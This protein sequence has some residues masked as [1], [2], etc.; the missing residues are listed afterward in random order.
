MLKKMLSITMAGL[1]GLFGLS[2]CAGKEN[3]GSTAEAVCLSG[4]SFFLTK[5]CDLIK[6]GELLSIDFPEGSEAAEAGA[7]YKV[8]LEEALRESWPPQG[9]ARK[10]EKVKEKS[11]VIKINWDQAE[12]IM[13]RL[14]EAAHLLDV[15]TAD[16]YASGYVPGALHAELAVL[17]TAAP[18]AV[19]EKDVPVIVYCRSGVRSAKAAAKLERMGYKMIFDAGGIMSYKGDIEKP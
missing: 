15:R 1:M 11:G 19:P 18:A 8:D 16:E 4:Q 10:V 14:P 6:E 2:G 9:T 17:E 7:V 5:G 13:S 3:A 12:K